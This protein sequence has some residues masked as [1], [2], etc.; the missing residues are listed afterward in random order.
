M[1]D[2]HDPMDQPPGTAIDEYNIPDHRRVIARDNT[3]QCPQGKCWFHA[4]ADDFDHRWN[5]G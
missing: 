2:V 1:I 5:T 3:N 4:A